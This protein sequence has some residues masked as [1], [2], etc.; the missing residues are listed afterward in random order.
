MHPCAG[1]RGLAA[2][3]VPEGQVCKVEAVAR[4]DYVGADAGRVRTDGEGRPWMAVRTTHD[5]HDDL[6]VFAP[7]ANGEARAT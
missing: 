4:G 6:V 5:D 7:L 3:L 1:L 2:P